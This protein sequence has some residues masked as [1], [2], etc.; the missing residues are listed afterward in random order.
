LINTGRTPEMQHRTKPVPILGKESR[1]IGLTAVLAVLIG[2]F[3]LILLTTAA[4]KTVA[5][6]IQ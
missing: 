1:A 4:L 3:A 6:R 5:G 2:A